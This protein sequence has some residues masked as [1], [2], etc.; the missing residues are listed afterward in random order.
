MSEEVKTKWSV[1]RDDELNTFH[2]YDENH[3][4]VAWDVKDRAKAQLMSAA[5]EL[6]AAC[7]LAVLNEE[8]ADALRG[9]GVVDFSDIK[10]LRAVAE[11]ARAAIA[12]AESPT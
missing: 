3:K 7:K 1:E 8:K 11:A 6:L 10:A 4:E 12:K 9:S 5:P 2:V